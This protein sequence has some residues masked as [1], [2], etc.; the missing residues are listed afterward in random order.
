MLHA[1]IHSSSTLLNAHL[2]IENLRILM[3][4]RQLARLFVPFLINCTNTHGWTP[5]KDIKCPIA[6]EVNNHSIPIVRPRVPPASATW[7]PQMILQFL[8][9]KPL[10]SQWKPLHRTPV[11]VTAL[12]HFDMQVEARKLNFSLHS[13]PSILLQLTVTPPPR[14]AHSSLW[15]PAPLYSPPYRH[16]DVGRPSQREAHRCSNNQAR[17]SRTVE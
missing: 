12:Q 9:Y 6:A 16:L 15:P 7:S 14:N 11:T 8:S 3:S 5:V 4:P 17:M 1:G 13:Y 2:A 10:T